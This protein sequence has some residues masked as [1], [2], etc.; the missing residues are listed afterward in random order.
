[1]RWTA[2]GS[3]RVLGGD[4][5]MD[6]R[7][8]QG[9][10]GRPAAPSRAGANGRAL[11]DP[12]GCA[13]CGGQRRVTDRRPR[14]LISLFGTVAVRTPQPCCRMSSR[15]RSAGGRY[16]PAAHLA[17]WRPAGARGD[18]TPDVR[19]DGRRGD[20]C[21]VDCLWS[22]ACGGSHQVRGVL[23]GLGATPG[24][25]VTARG[26]GADGPRSLRQA[27]CRPDLSCAGLVAPCD[28]H[29]PRR[30]GTYPRSRACR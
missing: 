10:P 15:W 13:R 25:E 19:A 1:M 20:D 4:A 8:G 14:R 16:H 30:P 9:G 29:P 18:C 27:A 23:Q 17:G 6:A 22:G 7:R 5:W 21:A 12:T 3:T 26:D 11:S 2:A 28:A 24:T